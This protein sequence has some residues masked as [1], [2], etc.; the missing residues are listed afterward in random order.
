VWS[1]GGCAGDDAKVG[2]AWG[3]PTV[4][5]L[6]EAVVAPGVHHPFLIVVGI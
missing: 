5:A 3:R 4:S 2:G 6:G 1:G